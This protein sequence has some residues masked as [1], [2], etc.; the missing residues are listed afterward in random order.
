MKLNVLLLVLIAGCYTAESQVK[1]YGLYMPIEFQN[2]YKK[3]TRKPDGSVSPTYRQNRS[4]YK[5][6]ASVNPHTH[7]LTGEA[8]ITYFNDSS[9]TVRNPTF[10]AYHDY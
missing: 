3:G 4:A 1:P 2:A 8:E 10:H 9:D 7:V 6:R 5:I